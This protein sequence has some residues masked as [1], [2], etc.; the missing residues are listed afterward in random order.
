MM[1]MMRA[2]LTFFSS[3]ALAVMTAAAI[4]AIAPWLSGHPS[5]TT[6]GGQ[7][8]TGLA[9]QS[10][11]HFESLLLG[12]VLGL[13]IGTMGRYNWGDIPRRAVTWVLIRERQFFYYTLIAGCVGVLL[14]Y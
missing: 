2:A 9:G 4:V 12:V 8:G 7:V 11:L 5:Q 6:L 1:A 13:V 14:F 10:G 3:L